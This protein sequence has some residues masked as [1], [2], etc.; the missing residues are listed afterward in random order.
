MNYVHAARVVYIEN[1]HNGSRLQKLIFLVC[2]SWVFA[3]CAQVAIK[4]P[5]MIVPII[6]HPLP[7]FIAV[8]FFD[9]YAV[10]AYVL[11]YAQGALGA[12]FFAQ[13]GSGLLKIAG[14]TGGYLLGMFFALA[15]I[16]YVREKLVGSYIF[17]L[18]ALLFAN[19]ILYTLGLIQLAFFV[20]SSQLLA[21][22]LYP[23]VGSCL[24]K[25]V[26]ALPCIVAPSFNTFDNQ[27]SGF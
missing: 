16:A 20:P 26:F 25:I 13:G 3:F 8:G 24:C 19:V 23:F 10:Y 1:V 6:F 4:F 11:Y 5:F 27:E 15:F 14:P 12:P 18:C 21:V 2:L 9:W 17:S 7:L 22:G